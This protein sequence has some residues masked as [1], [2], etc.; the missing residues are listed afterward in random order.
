MT[1]AWYIPSPYRP[2]PNS[3]Y[4]KYSDP[5]IEYPSVIYEV[6]IIE[7]SGIE[8][9]FYLEIKKVFWGMSLCPKPYS[10]GFKKSIESSVGC[11]YHQPK[12]DIFYT[13]EEAI[14]EH[15]VRLSEFLI[16]TTKIFQHQNDGLENY[17]N[18]LKD[19]KYVSPFTG[20]EK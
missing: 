19:E 8:D 9:R 1:Q 7:Q 16:E 15:K 12:R 10:Y 13:K 6:E 20:E 17:S 18:Y 5:K 11:K 4:A 3:P 14:E 2:D